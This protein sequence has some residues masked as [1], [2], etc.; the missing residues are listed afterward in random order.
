MTKARLYDKLCICKIIEKILAHSQGGETLKI[1]KQ[2]LL[3]TMADRKTAPSN[4]KSISRE[5]YYRAINGKSLSPVTVGKLAEE[6]GVKASDIVEV[7]P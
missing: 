7:E 6:L 3:L 5:T 1:S 2:K 4:I